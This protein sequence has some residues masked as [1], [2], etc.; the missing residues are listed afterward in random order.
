MGSARKAKLLAF[1]IIVLLITVPLSQ[2]TTIDTADGPSL[3]VGSDAGPCRGEG[4]IGEEPQDPIPI[5]TVVEG[6]EGNSSFGLKLTNVGDV[7]GDGI[8]DILLQSVDEDR[9]NMWTIALLPYLLPGREDRRF[10]LDQLQ[11]LGIENGSHRTPFHTFY[12][13]PWLGDVDGDGHADVW[14]MPPQVMWGEITYIPSVL[15]TWHGGPGGLPL[16]PDKA[17]SVPCEENL[18]SWFSCTF[19]GIGDVNGDGY[20]DAF[21][22]ADEWNNWSAGIG[23]YY[24]SQDGL[25]SRASWSSPVDVEDIKL[26][27]W[28]YPSTIATADVNADGYSDAIFAAEDSHRIQVHHGSPDGIAYDPDELILGP[29]RHNANIFRVHAPVDINGDDYEDAVFEKVGIYDNSGGSGDPDPDWDH[30]YVSVY[31]GGEGGLSKSPVNDLR[32]PVWP[33]KTYS[34][35]SRMELS[36][37]NGDGL[38]DIVLAHFE[39]RYGPEPPGTT[40]YT[41]TQSVNLT[42]DLYLNDNGTFGGRPDHTRN[43]GWI[44]ASWLSTSISGD[45]DGDGNGDFALGLRGYSWGH[46]RKE[47]SVRPGQVLI[48]SGE[49]LMQNLNPLVVYG[50]STLYARHRAYNFRVN[51]NPS[52]LLK[53]ASSVRLRLD[54]G[55]ANVTFQWVRGTGNGTFSELVDPL[56]YATIESGE[57][58]VDEWPESGHLF[59]NFRVMFDWDWP[60]ERLCDVVVTVTTRALR[61]SFPIERVFRVENDLQ[62]IGNLSARGE[63]QGALSEGDWVRGGERLRFHGLTAVYEGTTVIHPPDGACNLT[64]TDLEGRTNSTPIVSGAPTRVSIDAVDHTSVDEA[65]T[66]TLKDLP[67]NALSMNEHGFRLRVDGTPPELKNPVPDGDD[68][69]S[70]PST[71]A[72]ITVD[73][74]AT[75]GVDLTSIEYQYTTSGTEGYGNWSADGLTLSGDGAVVDA[76]VALELPDGEEN[77]I[78]WRARDMVGNEVVSEP[79]RMRVDTRNVTFRDP[80]HLPSGDD[81]SL[82]FTV[83]VTIL[84]LRGSG[85]DVSTIQYRVSHNNL[86]A[87]SEWYDWPEAH[88]QDSESVTASVAVL[89]ADTMHNHV[90]WRAMDV[91]GNGFTTSAHYRIGVDIT[92]IAFTGT[93]PMEGEVHNGTS[94]EFEVGVWDN[95]GGVGV[96]LS[97]LQYRYALSEEPGSH[98][99][100][101]WS[102]WVD[103]GLEGTSVRESITLVLELSDGS[104]NRVQ[105]RG[106]D[107][108]GNG[109]TASMAY[110]ITIDTTAP[111]LLWVSPEP[112]EKQLDEEVTVAVALRDEVAGVDP[113]RVWYRYSTT[114]EDGFG[115]WTPMEVHG[116]RSGDRY[117]GSVLVPFERGDGNLVQFR[118]ADLAG[119]VATY[120]SH[121]IWVNRPPVAVISSPADGS[122]V[123]KGASVR[124]DANGTA[125]PDGDD[126]TYHWYLDMSDEP[127]STGMTTYIILEAGTQT[128]TLL[129]R[130]ADGLETNAS[131]EVTA[132]VPQGRPGPEAPSMAVVLALVFVLVALL[133]VVEVLRRRAGERGP[134][135]EGGR[136]PAT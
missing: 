15:E 48:F 1:A 81:K 88:L 23:V 86:S 104:G 47:K 37:V 25:P 126:M 72:S 40:D 107:M 55:G 125:D 135:T 123:P 89:L 114:G 30:R 108:A 110:G 9:S 5:C 59:L 39:R 33:F 49:G 42:V 6:H 85:I 18:T 32:L 95:L 113:D 115:G 82:W 63:R 132:L 20:D 41:P 73:D 10:D 128:V 14:S 60:H 29:Y 103:I 2:S 127:V 100:G 11:L 52:G 98:V 111:E 4:A 134:G 76:M 136:P 58:D 27:G 38:D 66:L 83:G 61:T 24:G 69:H 17:I 77:H 121:A 68:W 19:A 57:G 118:A 43:L 62:L 94:V 51:A 80:F 67:W 87:Y 36:D 56:D 130:D 124:L 46:Y 97:S 133:T 12:D 8:D 92:P 70:E 13:D 90:Q 7:N 131:I 64:V 65:Y 119:N 31:V 3:E 112:D 75:S 120:G 129:A 117:L 50:G 109:P 99:P 78:R 26:W 91:A 105:L 102:E 35:Q 45:F 79:I 96:N 93:N 53:D 122:E 116:R 21:A 54:P 44:N 28:L 22:F 34:E 101:E 16:E 84:D 71:P 74:S 106:W